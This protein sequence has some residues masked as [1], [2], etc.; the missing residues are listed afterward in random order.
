MGLNFGGILKNFEC[1]VF[2]CIIWELKKWGDF[3]FKGIFEFFRAI[4][5]IIL[6]ILNGLNVS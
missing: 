5:I 3:L 6:S 2:F 4:L 1:F